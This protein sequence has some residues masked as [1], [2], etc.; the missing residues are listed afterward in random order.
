MFGSDFLRRFLKVFVSLFII[1]LIICSSCLSSFAFNSV[2]KID[3]V[4]DCDFD[5]YFAYAQDVSTS[6]D[7][8]DVV[9]KFIGSNE[10]F[11]LGSVD[12][13]GFSVNTAPDA[14]SVELLVHVNF[15]TQ[16]I[17]SEPLIEYATRGS[18]LI[19]TNMSGYPGMIRYIDP[20]LPLPTNAFYVTNMIHS[21]INSFGL[22]DT[23]R[24]YIL[25]NF[26]EYDYIFYKYIKQSVTSNLLSY[27][28]TATKPV[29]FD[30][31]NYIQTAKDG[32]INNIYYVP[33]NYKSLNFNFDVTKTSDDYVFKYDD[34]FILNADI[35]KLNNYYVYFP[36]SKL[37]MSYENYAKFLDVS[38]SDELIKLS[39][40]DDY[41]VN[42]DKTVTGISVTSNFLE[43]PHSSSDIG[44]GSSIEK[45]DDKY[46]TPSNKEQLLADGW[47]EGRPSDKNYPFCVAIYRNGQLFNIIYLDKQPEVTSYFTSDNFIKYKIYLYKRTG[48]VYNAI[49]NV[50]C[51]FDM[52]TSEQDNVYSILMENGGIAM[53]NWLIH[54]GGMTDDELRSMK[55]EQLYLNVFTNYKGTKDNYIGYIVKFNWDINKTILKA[56]E[57]NDNHDYSDDVDKNVGQYTDNEGH[58]HGGGGS[59]SNNDVVFGSLFDFSSGSFSGAFKNIQDILSSFLSTTNTCFQFLKVSFGLLPA[60]VWVIISFSIIISIIGRQPKLLLIV[61]VVAGVLQVVNAL[62]GLFNGGITLFGGG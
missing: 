5:Y 14:F 23:F 11:I 26:H 7:K 4:P 20:V 36:L 31:K 6:H 52:T 37:Y 2:Y 24:S 32:I 39:L 15:N 25:G 1:A 30:D 45:A 62:T 13:G 42:D 8:S 44:V 56:E 59:S 17:L 51:Y 18:T 28:A 35:P 50:Y 10:K 34:G 61:V 19:T 22:S 49:N 16:T 54:Q 33:D 9:V 3:Y 47:K 46:F 40:V 58:I 41:K 12:P 57:G 21:D 60:W 27:G 48:Y 38:D 43:L 29:D 55:N 53:H